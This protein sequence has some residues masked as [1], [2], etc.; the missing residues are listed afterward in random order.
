MAQQKQIQVQLQEARVIDIEMF[1]KYQGK[2]IVAEIRG[3]G[4]LNARLEQYGEKFVYLTDCKLIDYDINSLVRPHFV[5][6]PLQTESQPNQ[7]ISKSSIER[8]ILTGDLLK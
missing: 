7:I 2:N 4:T 3:V 5:P 1:G 6:L 8:I